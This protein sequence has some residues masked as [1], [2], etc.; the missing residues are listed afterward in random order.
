M[1]VPSQMISMKTARLFMRDTK[2]K[3]KKER[4]YLHNIELGILWK[5]GG[6]PWSVKDTFG[7]K[8]KNIVIHRD[9]FNNEDVEW[10]EHYFKA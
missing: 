6:I 10:Y 3:G 7:E 5:T 4:Y 2:A 9:G 8:A 1:N